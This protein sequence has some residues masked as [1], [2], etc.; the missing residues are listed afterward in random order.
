MIEAL[1][2]D[3]DN[4]LLDRGASAARYALGLAAR[5]PRAFPPERRAADLAAWQAQDGLGYAHPLET[6][7]WV[8]ERFPALGLTAE[9]LWADFRARLPECVEPDPAV[10]ALLERL[11][12]RFRLGL[13]SNGDGA[14]QR[15]KLE[16][17][18]LARFFPAPVISGEV[19]ADKPDSAPFRRA[20]A[21][22]ECPP[23]RAVFVGDHPVH[24]VAGARAV[25]LRVCWLSLGR[26]WAEEAPAPDWIIGRLAELEAAL[27]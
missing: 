15:A 3:L 17:A 8:T 27:T 6:C 10:V 13:V 24:D 23:A 18:G 14:L 9:A 25:G 22:A 20:L 21:I 26:A 16:R 12:A 5:F 11:G 7:R 19:G 1:L 2:F 4:T